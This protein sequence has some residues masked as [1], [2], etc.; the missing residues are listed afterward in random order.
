MGAPSRAVVVL[1]LGAL[2]AGALPATSACNSLSGVDD[3]VVGGGAD[4]SEPNSDAT[5]GDGASGPD[6]SQPH[7][8]QGDVDAAAQ[9]DGRGGDGAVSGGDAAPTESGGDGPQGPDGGDSAAP[10]DAASDTT[11]DGK[12]DG[13]PTNDGG[14][15][16]GDAATGQTDAHT[17]SPATGPC[18][19]GSPLVVH[20]NGFGQ[21]FSDCVPLSTYNVTQ[22]F[23]ACA[24]STGDAGAC[25]VDPGGLSCSGG[26]VV[27]TVTSSTCACWRYDNRSGA[28]GS[29][30]G[31]CACISNSAPVL[32]N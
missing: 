3:F 12:A 28:I 19:G 15:D 25:T 8:A 31:A 30:S 16:A 18:D 24:A 21:T 29:F 32:W 27:C 20:S 6:G 17:D 5:T 26:N 7:D 2:A 10:Q 22:A 9:G 23:E 14:G 1:A 4:S 13:N 11:S